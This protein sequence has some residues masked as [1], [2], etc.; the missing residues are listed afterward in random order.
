MSF[1]YRDDVIRCTLESL[2]CILFENRL[3]KHR[4]GYPAA[5]LLED[6]SGEVPLCGET[7][8]MMGCSD[9]ALLHVGDGQSSSS[10]SQ[11]TSSSRS[12]FDGSGEDSGSVTVASDS[13]TTS[14]TA[15]ELTPLCC[16]DNSGQDISMPQ[17]DQSTGVGDTKSLPQCFDVKA[18]QHLLCS[19]HHPRWK[20][21]SK[22][23]VEL[24]DESQP[25]VPWPSPRGEDIALHMG[26]R[27]MDIELPSLRVGSVEV[28]DELS[29]RQEPDGHS[30]SSESVDL[31]SVHTEASEQLVAV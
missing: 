10:D 2:S 9:R 27:E 15:D 29:G 20:I 14:V 13:S 6:C 30:I 4:S 26:V 18:S 23:Y 1:N 19:S 8:S 31:A 5:I 3:K 7:P 12:S 28:G 25:Q 16:H 24:P 11:C 22:G 17:T 21:N